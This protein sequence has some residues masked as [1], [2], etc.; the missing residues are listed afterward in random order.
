MVA[1]SLPRRPFTSFLDSTC[2]SGLT[3]MVDVHSP[4]RRS[5]N[6]S[7][8]RGRNTKPEWAMRRGLHALGFRYRLHRSDLPGRPDM[9][10]SA[11]RTVV[12]VHGCFWHGHGCPMGRPPAS[13]VAFWRTKIASNRDR[14]RRAIITLAASGWRV[15]IVWECAIRGPARL[16]KDSA[17]ARCAE[18]LRSCDQLNEEITGNWGVSQVHH[19]E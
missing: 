11:R 14:D 5:Y 2:R 6:M 19:D 4:E 13:R 18:F 8:I 9:V 16:P 12:F 15:L 7:R 3:P 1:A 10:F 17:L